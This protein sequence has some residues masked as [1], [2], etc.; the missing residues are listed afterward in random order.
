MAVGSIPILTS[1]VGC[2]RLIKQNKNGFVFEYGDTISFANCINNLAENKS[3]RKNIFFKCSQVR[4]KI[5]LE[6]YCEV[7]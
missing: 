6:K 5:N 1:Q 7:N 2:S 3:L 4:F